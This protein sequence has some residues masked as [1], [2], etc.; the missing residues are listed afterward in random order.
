MEITDILHLVLELQKLREDG[1]MYVNSF[2]KI[3]NAPMLNL[4]SH[5]SAEAEDWANI[6]ASRGKV[7]RNPTTDEAENVFY[8]C[9][10]NE[11]VVRDAVISWFVF[12]TFQSI[13]NN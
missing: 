12:L 7:E 8:R 2:R 9:G 13:A 4:D 10:Q 6:L 5:M 11:H 1:V 3:H